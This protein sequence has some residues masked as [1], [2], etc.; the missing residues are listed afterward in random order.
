LHLA[1]GSGSGGLGSMRSVRDGLFR[2]P[3]LSARRAE[4]RGFLQRNGLAYD[5][6]PANDDLRFARN[7]V[8]REAL[9]ALASLNPRLYEALARTAAVLAAEDDLLEALARARAVGVRAPD[10]SALDAAAL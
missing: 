6:D 1:R 4:L 3:L 10:A 5:E 9:P 8:R 2:R 7:R